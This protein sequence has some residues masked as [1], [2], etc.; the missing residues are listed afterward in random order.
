MSTRN[1]E[2][3][4]LVLVGILGTAAFGSAWIA[5][6]NRVSAD[7][8]VDVAVIAAVFV[9]AHI[10]VRYTAPQ[11]EPTLLPI[12]ALLTAIGL[13]VNYRL[14]PADGKKQAVWVAIGVVAFAV[15]LIALRFDYRILEQYRYLF[16]VS[17]IG[18][19]LLR[20]C[21]VSGNASTACASGSTSAASSSSP[22][23]WRSCS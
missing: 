21:P 7:G 17:A 22:A 4:N 6:T 16:G 20:R 11:A 14:D 10:V 8:L 1:R 15:T 12:A 9:A 5:R 3:V 2:L 13:T 18:L 19:L 23:R